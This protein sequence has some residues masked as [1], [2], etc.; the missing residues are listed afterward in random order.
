MKKKKKSKSGPILVPGTEEELK[1]LNRISGQMEGIRKMLENGR[2]LPDIL[3]Q[4][5]A[6]HA[7]LKSI[8]LRVLKA[9]L[10]SATGEA[11]R[12][13]GR[14]AKDKKIDEILALFKQM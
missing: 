10:E 3:V 5:K 12:A 4:F 13:Q 8:E 7:A 1:R 9:H 11:A 2:D 6:I 14:K